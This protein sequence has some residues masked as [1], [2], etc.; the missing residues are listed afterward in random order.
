[1]SGVFLKVNKEKNKRDKVL[2]ELKL[3][4]AQ[5]QNVHIRFEQTSDSDL[6]EAAIYEMQA[7]KARHRYLVKYAKMFDEKAENNE[8]L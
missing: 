2:E 1:M 3:V 5:L 7:L 6:I 4:K 8:N